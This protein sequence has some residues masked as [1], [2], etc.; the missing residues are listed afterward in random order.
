MLTSS[1]R[2]LCARFSSLLILCLSDLHDTRVVN[3]IIMHTLE[4]KSKKRQIKKLVLGGGGRIH[5]TE[6]NSKLMLCCGK[7][8]GG[9]RGGEKIYLDKL[10]SL[11]T[12]PC[13]PLHHFTAAKAPGL[14]Y[15]QPEPHHSQWPH[16]YHIQEGHSATVQ[17]QAVDWHLRDVHFHREFRVPV[18][19]NLNFLGWDIKLLWLF[20]I[21]IGLKSVIW[22]ANVTYNPVL[23]KE[24]T[25][26]LIVN[27]NTKC[28]SAVCPACLKVLCRPFFGKQIQPEDVIPGDGSCHI[29]ILIEE[30]KG[31]KPKLISGWLWDFSGR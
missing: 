17:H 16:S 2:C 23:T 10:Q 4:K 21:F 26:N 3:T 25:S 18:H 28:L 9:G 11:F 20:D 31:Q 8:G 27:N 14:Q 7:G 30:Q 12:R 1:E 24:N 13:D 5:L 19:L 22:W 29:Y 15:E 6:P